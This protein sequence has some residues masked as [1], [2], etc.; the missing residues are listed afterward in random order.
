MR[1]RQQGTAGFTITIN[2]SGTS[3]L[4]SCCFAMFF[5]RF[6]SFPCVGRFHVGLGQEQGGP[7]VGLLHELIVRGMIDI[8]PNKE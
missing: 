4:A 8:V 6:R 1:Y 3:C 2:P 7:V 5:G